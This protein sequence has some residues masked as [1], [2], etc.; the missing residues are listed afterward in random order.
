MAVVRPAPPD[1]A[2]GEAFRE[3]IALIRQ[4]RPPRRG[5]ACR[6]VVDVGW[7]HET[8]PPDDPA[9]RAAR[10]QIDDDH[11]LSVVEM[12]DSFS[13][14]Q[15]DIRMPKINWVLQSSGDEGEALS[16]TAA[17]TFEEAIARAEAAA[18]V[19]LGQTLDS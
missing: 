17:P 5:L 14:E 7:K 13:A 11:F 4:N 6:A 8:M 1:D 18:R 2:S 10:A 16:G 12:R 19:F 9:V 15:L 3:V